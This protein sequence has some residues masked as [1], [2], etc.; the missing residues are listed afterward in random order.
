MNLSK[1][2]NDL[3]VLILYQFRLTFVFWIS[4]ILVGVIISTF[5]GS[6][7]N[8]LALNLDSMG[9]GILALV[10]AAVIGAVSPICLYGTIPVMAVLSKKGL[11]HYLLATFM[12]SSVM[13]NPNLFI[14]SFVLGVPLALTRLGVSILAG[15]AAGAI[16]RCF[17]KGDEFFNFT[18]FEGRKKRSE[19][20]SI[21]KKFFKEL[22]ATIVTITPYF[23]VGIILTALFEKYVPRNILLALFGR[24]KGFGVLLAATLGVPVYVCGGGTIPLLN[25]CINAGMSYG[26]AIAFMITGPA[27]KLT[28]LSAVKVILGKRNFVLYIVFVLVF[29]VFAGLIA[30]G[31][32]SLWT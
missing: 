2:L 32:L 16:V 1:E 9:K 31:L 24:N 17:I 25:S 19:D 3:Y 8:K 28:N 14:F 26:S 6:R 10:F 23:F 15:I 12:V 11:P 29:S 22:N 27:T 30:D 4:G 18:A 21:V 13:I 7:L 5:L 20:I